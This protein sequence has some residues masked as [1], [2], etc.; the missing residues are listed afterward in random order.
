MKR[1]DGANRHA[2][3]QDL[4]IT[5]KQGGVDKKVARERIQDRVL[6]SIHHGVENS[7]EGSFVFC[8]TKD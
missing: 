1:Y 7:T 3:C 2:S 6:S 8:H 4:L 5:G